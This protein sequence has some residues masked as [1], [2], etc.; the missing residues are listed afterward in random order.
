MLYHVI[1]AFTGGVGFTRVPDDP[2]VGHSLMLTAL[3]YPAF[4]RESM[5]SPLMWCYHAIVAFTGA[6]GAIKLLDG[7]DP[8]VGYSLMLTALLYASLAYQDRVRG[9]A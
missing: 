6:A 8:V 5:T 9:L 1:I 2:V 7:R 4:R 3:L